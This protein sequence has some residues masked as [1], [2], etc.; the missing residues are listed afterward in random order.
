MTR[1]I[2]DIAVSYDTG[3]ADREANEWISTG[4]VTIRQEGELVSID[5]KRGS[6][7]SVYPLSGIVLI[8]M[9]SGELDYFNL[10]SRCLTTKPD[11]AIAEFPCPGFDPGKTSQLA[12]FADLSLRSHAIAWPG[13][14]CPAT[15]PRL[16]ET[17]RFGERDRKAMTE[18]AELRLG[19]GGRAIVFALWK[20]IGKSLSEP[21]RFFISTR[22]HTDYSDYLS[23]TIGEARSIRAQLQHPSLDLKEKVLELVKASAESWGTVPTLA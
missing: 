17:L 3:Y 2:P 11:T 14:S 18:K 20:S 1:P 19:S 23:L 12:H 13:W 9:E 16:F 15:D 8:T 6:I 4:K 7:S 5:G 10:A 22:T 21:G